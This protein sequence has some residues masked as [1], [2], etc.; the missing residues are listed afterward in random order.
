MAKLIVREGPG[1]GTAYELVDD[2]T[3]IGRDPNN[4]VQIP[5]ETV[6]RAHA[7]V[8]R[9]QE[10]NIESWTIT[11]LQ[12]K[13]GILLNGR[14]VDKA[15]LTSNDEIRLG[16]VV[17]TFIE[18]EFDTLEIQLTETE[19]EAKLKPREV[20]RGETVAAGR[21]AVR[22]G[23]I[24]GDDAQKR[25]LAI[26]ELGQVAASAK[27]YPELFA[28]ISS[29]VEGNLRPHRTVPILFDE[30]KGI[31]R[32]W[33]SQRGEFDKH[34]AQIPISSTIVNY[35]REKREAILSEAAQEDK[36]LQ[37]ARSITT[38]RI[39]SAMCAPMLIGDRL[40][41]AIYADRLGDAEGFTRADLELLMALAAQAAVAVENVRVHEEMGRER[42][43]REREARGAYDIVG[44]C[45]AMEEVFRFIA[46]AA[47]T[48]S[49]VLIEGE[50][51][52][53]KE[54]VARAL[55][56]NSRRRHQPF[57][58][59]NCAAMAPTL[60]ESELFGHVRGAYTGADRDRPGRFEL[61]DGGALFLD[62]IG[63]L[64]DSSQSKLLRVIEA[65]E[66]RRVGDV[67][68][69]KVDVRVIAATNKKL[70]VEVAAG[71]FREDLY[72]RLNVLKISLPPL[73]ERAGDVRVL[74]EHFLKHFAEK[75]GRPSLALD[76]KVWPLFESYP[77]PGNVRELR[78]A[79]ERMVVMAE[80]DTLRLEDIPF[81]IRSGKAPSRAAETP[82]SGPSG[83]MPT[84]RDLEKT[85]IERVMRLTGGNKK[86]TARILGIDRSTLY[87]KLKAYGLETK[88]EETKEGE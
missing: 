55:H 22:H 41:G 78:N 66:L 61:A 65:G 79:I 1:R 15:P 52:T 2:A 21:P 62:E 34:L 26:L 53:G 86:E 56:L 81:E 80:G 11:D 83:E 13:N 74:S 28:A 63:E 64:P 75:C 16:E 30:Q 3:K 48:D 8:E 19:A 77:W 57:E 29:A 51:G 5:S 12:S 10:G 37:D 49:G 38:H 9:Q 23:V 76:N 31:L 69:R 59:A 27:S 45:K 72:F 73:R 6:S 14:R 42:Y 44:Q 43:L 60:L 32:P 70:I 87:A 71:R 54:L 47:P 50:S 24:A 88:D 58:A 36:R 35:V 67:K 40:L 4:A 68:D 33:V 25:L 20:V 46:K 85:H 7:V 18:K 17:L 84:L 39:T 82:G